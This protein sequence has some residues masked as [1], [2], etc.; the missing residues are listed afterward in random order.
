MRD[1]EREYYDRRDRHGRRGF[2]IWPFV[3]GIL[4]IIVG[5]SYILGISLNTYFWSIIAIVVGISIIVGAI[6]GRSRRY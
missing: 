1:D 2:R 5:L 6:L 4:L 3:I